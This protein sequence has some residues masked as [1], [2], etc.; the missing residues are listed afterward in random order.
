MGGSI[1][2][3]DPVE[4]LAVAVCVNQLTL[5]RTCM[6]EIV[7]HVTQEFGTGELQQ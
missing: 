1:A 3:C 2:F 4:H 6:F 7:N 5:D